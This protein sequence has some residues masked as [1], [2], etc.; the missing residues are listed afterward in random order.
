MVRGK[1]GESET[2]KP[3]DREVV[4]GNDTAR[5]TIDLG[6]LIALEREAL[7][8]NDKS[9]PERPRAGSC[10]MSS[11]RPGSRRYWIERVELR[12]KPRPTGAITLQPKVRPKAGECRRRHPEQCD[13]PQVWA[14]AGSPRGRGRVDRLVRGGFLDLIGLPFHTH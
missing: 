4:E 9:A 8:L 13:H 14:S 5:A 10:P 7:G 12:P 6:T 3:S 2:N 1:V 11:A